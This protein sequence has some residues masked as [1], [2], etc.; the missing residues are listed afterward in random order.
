MMSYG[1]L[2]DEV[3]D[4]NLV[5]ALDALQA[6][7]DHGLDDPDRP[8]EIGR[9]AIQL[10][11]NVFQVRGITIN[12]SHMSD[13]LALLKQGRSLDPVTLWRCGGHALLVDGHHRLAA[14][15][16]FA[17][18]LKRSVPVPCTWFE[19]SAE[20]AMHEAMRTNVKVK[21]PMSH[22]QR[23]NL[24]WKLVQADRF[25][26]AQIVRETGVA[27]GTVAT[28]RRV[29][30]KLVKMAISTV[31]SWWQALH[32]VK[33]GEGEPVDPSEWDAKEALEAERHVKALKKAVGDRWYRKPKV[34][35]MALDTFIGRRTPDVMRDWY[36]MTDH[37]TEED[38]TEWHRY[39][40][41]GKLPDGEDF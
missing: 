13:L 35:A 6:M 2:D 27:E 15:G 16:A 23:A 38:V 5:E 12:E 3:F 18:H 1:K 4:A 10:V 11:P 26:K 21:L 40:F 37:L 9:K 33:H 34:A 22:E 20:E 8:T 39:R 32:R 36:E 31:G 25:S 30:K 24:A 41:D 14:Y 7:K 19:G 29:L 17:Q 28:M